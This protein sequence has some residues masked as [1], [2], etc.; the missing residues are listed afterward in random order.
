MPDDPTPA[1]FDRV[2]QN[3]AALGGAINEI[4]IW[5][6]KSGATDVSERIADQLKVL[7]GNTDAIAKLMA[8]LIARWTPEEE[9]D[10]ED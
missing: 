10:P 2:N 7:E 1:L 5:M 6:A 4:G 3:I 8:D 9:I